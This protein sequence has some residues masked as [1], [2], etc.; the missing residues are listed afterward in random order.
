ME[1][2]EID[3]AQIAYDD[4]GFDGPAVVLIHGGTTDRRMWGRQVP[5]LRDRFRVI[6][7]DWLGYGDSGDVVADHARHE[8]LLA[9]L[10]RLGVDDAVLVGSSDGG[11]LSLDTAL[12]APE[13]VAG[14]V[15]VGSGLSGHTWPESFT[16]LYRQRVHHR[17]GIERLRAYYGGDAGP[18]DPADL[19]LYVDSVVEL[20]LAGP[21]RTRQDIEPDIW[22]HAVGMYRRTAERAWAG[23]ARAG[24]PQ[25]LEPGAAKRLGEVAVP[26]FVV[27]GAEDVPEIVAVSEQLAAE[28]PGALRVE[29]PATGHVPPLE[30]P[31]EF[32]RLL[33]EFLDAFEAKEQ[34]QGRD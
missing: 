12:T 27:Y 23:A 6:S 3:G 13:R 24:S 21:A 5:V 31:E 32:N 20:L 1:K 34:A 19:A 14:L 28:I 9:L 22:A 10:D 2:V 16:R 17:V 4:D 29:M 26:T 18:V 25:D 8:Q 30:R 33:L 11:K 15:L 7:Y